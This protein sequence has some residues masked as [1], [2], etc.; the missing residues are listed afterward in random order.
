MSSPPRGRGTRRPRKRLKAFKELMYQC[1]EAEA[2][3]KYN[4]LRTSGGDFDA[5]PHCR[6]DTI[7]R[8]GDKEQFHRERAADQQRM[9]SA[10]SAPGVSLDAERQRVRQ[11]ESEEWQDYSRQRDEE[12]RFREGGTPSPITYDSSLPSKATPG[13]STKKISWAEY[14]SR[15]P[16]DHREQTQEK[17]AK[18]HEEMKRQQEELES[19]RCEVDRLKQEQEELVLEREHLCAGQEQLDHLRAEQER[20]VRLCVEQQE[21][22]HLEQERQ[23]P[24]RTEQGHLAVQAQ[25]T[26]GRQT[27]FGSHTPVHDE[28][29]EDLDYIDNLEHEERNAE[30]W[31]RLIADAP[32]NKQLEQA[33]SVRELQEAALLEGPTKAAMPTEEEVLLAADSRRP[34]LSQ[35]IQQL[36]GLQDSALSELSQHIDEI[37]WQMPSSASPSKSPGPPPGLPHSM[38]QTTEMA[39]S[40]LEATTHLGQLPSGERPITQMPDDEETERATDFLEAQMKA[41]G[42][43]LQGKDL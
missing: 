21:H 20:Q 31:R 7:R 25:A 13:A 11:A 12:I 16:R 40:I 10:P 24:P 35:L 15:P 17:E 28:H 6:I 43:P 3:C 22:W 23:E 41:P 9:K 29:V 38:P 33:A 42:T 4:D 1:Y 34:G 39:G 2:I 14:Q 32:I 30:T 8:P 27:P 26:A 5:L 19:R 18:W 37:R 36:Q